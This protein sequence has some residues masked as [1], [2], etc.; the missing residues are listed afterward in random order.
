MIDQRRLQYFVAV[1]EELHFGRAA[2]RLGIAQPPLSQQIQKL[3]AELGA[4]LFERTRRSVALTSAGEALLPEARRLLVMAERAAEHAREVH[5]GKAGTLRMGMIGSAAYRL[6]PELLRHYRQRYPQVKFELTEMATADQLDRVEVGTLDLGL[7]R[8]PVLREGLRTA[9]VWS[10]PLI[11]ALPANHRLA[12]YEAIT[13]ADLRD[14]P[15]VLFPRRSGPGLFETISQMCA[16][17]GFS[18]NV[19]QEAVQMQTIVGFVGAGFGVAIVPASVRDFRLSGVVYRPFREQ[20]PSSNIALIWNEQIPS[21]LRDRFLQIATRYTVPEIE[22][23]GKL[24][25]AS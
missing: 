19:V 6:V 3:E 24:M 7:V 8:P 13:V 18:P 12:E 25:V 17:N 4:Q 5:E 21:R 14:E 11:A 9:V 1:A 16:D 23:G 20:V 2:Q 10:E 15:F 22:I